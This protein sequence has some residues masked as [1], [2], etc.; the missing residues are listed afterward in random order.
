[1]FLS[2]FYICFVLA[3]LIWQ[4]KY[5][6]GQGNVLTGSYFKDDKKYVKIDLKKL[7]VK[8]ILMG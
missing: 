6:N 3:F 4:L 7:E 5:D 8:S 1:M 2:I